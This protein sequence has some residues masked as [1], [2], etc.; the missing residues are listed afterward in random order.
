MAD[1][2]MWLSHSRMS[3]YVECPLYYKLAYIDKV[4]L[5][6]KGNYHTALGNG[7]HK[8]LEEMYRQGKYTLQFME[9]WW[10]V[11]CRNGYTEKNG[12]DVKPILK[13]E[14]YDFPNGDE[15]KNMFFYHGRKLIREYYHKNKHD[16]G[17]NQIV[18]TE[19]N[20]KVPIAGGKIVLNGYIDRVD[21]APNGMLY[22]YD[23]KTGK[24]KNQEEVDEDFQMT[25]YSFAIRKTFGEVEG[26]V[27]MHFIKSGNIVVS[28]RE[29]EDFMKLRERVKYVKDGIMAGRFE[30]NLGGQC[31][32]CLYDCPINGN[33]LKKSIED[34]D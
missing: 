33:K 22:I 31:R 14:Q 18:A 28:T 13:D 4:Q 6:I 17:V 8:V 9:Q 12:M 34:P 16:F 23:Y 7:I 19:L 10:D 27:G 11:V 5:N 32:Y 3:A 29:A 20:F 21:R 1:N 30:P 25:L 24:E 15:E 2:Q 26:G